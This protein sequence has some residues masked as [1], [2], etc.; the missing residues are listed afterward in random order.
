MTVLHTENIFF[1][2]QA[3]TYQKWS[4]TTIEIIN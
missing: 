4:V 1:L 3:Y 2:S